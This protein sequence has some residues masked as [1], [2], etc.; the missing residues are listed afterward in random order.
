M[1]VLLPKEN[2]T[3]TDI[4][5]LLNTDNWKSWTENFTKKAINLTIPKFKSSYQKKL[6][7]TLIDLGLGN[8]FS[9]NANFSGISDVSLKISYVLQKTFI[10]VNEKG[11]E[12]AAVT[13]VGLENTSN[14]PN[15]EMIINKPF[16]YTITEKET[17]SIC[18]V[19]KIGMPKDE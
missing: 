10:E 2:K 13:V 16:L 7:E 5:N 12:A 11:T 3:T 4:I 14:Q 15:K 1:T 18:F 17:G 9:A 8:A 19:G 6:N